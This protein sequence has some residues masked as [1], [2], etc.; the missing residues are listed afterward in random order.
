[1]TKFALSEVAK[2]TLALCQFDSTTGAEAEVINYLDEWCKNQGFITK[3]QTVGDI[4]GRDNLLVYSP[5][6]KPEILMSTHV[7]T[8]PIYFPP[9]YDEE[10]NL[11]VG[12][13]V[14]DAKGIAATMLY[15]LVELKNADVTNVGVLLLVGEETNSDGAKKAV[16]NFAPKVK[17]LING[18]PTNLELASS[19]K[20]AIVFELSALGKTGHSAYP[21][22]G[23]SATHVLVNDIHAL[24]NFSWPEDKLFGLTT[25]NIGSITGGSAVNVLAE[26]AIAKGIIRTTKSATDL[27]EI[28]QKIISPSTSLKI[29]SSSSPMQLKTVAGFKQ[30]I[31]SFGSDV[32]H[33]QSLA[34]PLLIGP[35]SILN[36]HTKD[37]S[38]AVAELKKAVQVY[39]KLCL[40]LIKEN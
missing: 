38:I 2:L 30:C 11:L 21:E 10:K 34:T 37:E 4:A 33:L 9:R 8:V 15:A 28:I 27:I 36:A 26:S 18:E 22:S 7:D 23:K 20:G 17:Y 24:I 1:M 25:I 3:R 39:K 16:Q 13:G 31:V 40:Q 14:L 29:L 5:N 12:R 35:G 19:M 32:P 6:T